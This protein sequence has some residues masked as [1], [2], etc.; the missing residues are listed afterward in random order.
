MSSTKIQKAKTYRLFQS[1]SQKNLLAAKV[2][3]GVEQARRTLLNLWDRVT[4]LGKS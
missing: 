3:V 4:T 2:V 1:S